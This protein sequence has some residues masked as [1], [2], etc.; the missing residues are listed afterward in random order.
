MT[1]AAR[2]V[3]LLALAASVAGNPSR[4]GVLSE[5]KA[6]QTHLDGSAHATSKL[7][8]GALG[9]KLLDVAPSSAPDLPTKLDSFSHTNSYGERVMDSFWKVIIGVILFF[10]S[11]LFLYFVEGEACKS[12]VMM[13]H[14]K[15]A[16]QKE[17]TAEK[18][19]RKYQN[20]MV[21]V[22]GPM[23]TE[24]GQR[25]EDLGFTPA[26]KCVVLKRTVEVLQWVEHKHKSDD[27]TTYEYKME[28]KEDDVDSSG[29]QH[30]V[31]H[32]NNPRKHNFHSKK[33]T[34]AQVK[35]Q[36]FELKANVLEKLTGFN[37]PVMK[38]G[39]HTHKDFVL[40][41]QN[42]MCGSG[43]NPG[44]MKITYQ[45]DI[46]NICMYLFIPSKVKDIYYIGARRG[47]CVYLRCSDRGHVPSFPYGA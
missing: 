32:E 43:E 12:L 23:T 30:P 25:D 7:Q 17:I 31:G 21:H 29:F 16:C 24:T 39:M 33:I 19:Q 41:E 13:N 26:D 3:V 34:S 46:R 40:C 8:S 47:T 20:C 42:L 11:F 38:E 9:K 10:S 6:L 35:L 14:A 18:V 28:W 27:T 5:I 4:S 44:D 36:A 2:A 37:N 1:G 22:T 15:K 45:V